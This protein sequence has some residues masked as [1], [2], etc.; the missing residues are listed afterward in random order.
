[1]KAILGKQVSNALN[2]S[3]KKETIDTYTLSGFK[4]GEFRELVT[5]RWYM[6]RSSQ[7]SQIYCSVWVHG[8]NFWASGKGTAG[9]YGYC[10]RSAAFAEAL[11]SADIKLFGSPYSGRDTKDAQK[12]PCCISG[13]GMTAVEDAM[14]AIG[15][16][17]GYKKV[18]LVRG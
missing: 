8:D 1:M 12:T 16:A 6:G 3:G 13:T 11:G 7:A 14:K 15:A 5:A 4:K 9:G 10:K 18:H 17:L 2:Y